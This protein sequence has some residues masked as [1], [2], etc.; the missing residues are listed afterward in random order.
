[1]LGPILRSWRRG[2][3]KAAT[4][5]SHYPIQLTRPQ[6]VWAGPSWKPDLGAGW[7]SPGHCLRSLEG[8]KEDGPDCSRSPGVSCDQCTHSP[9]PWLRLLL[10]LPP[11]AGTQGRWQRVRQPRGCGSQPHSYKST[12]TCTHTHLLTHSQKASC[13]KLIKTKVPSDNPSP[14]TTKIA[15][16]LTFSF[17]FH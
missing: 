15:M 1:M 8:G 16:W 13:N 5:H 11:S 2:C 4:P 10:L 17:F 3:G 14:G 12:H 9:S 6:P 7:P